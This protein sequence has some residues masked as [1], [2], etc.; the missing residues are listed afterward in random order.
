MLKLS[1]ILLDT[2]LLAVM[3]EMKMENIFVGVMAEIHRAVTE[4]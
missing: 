4:N 1:V 2:F 3:I